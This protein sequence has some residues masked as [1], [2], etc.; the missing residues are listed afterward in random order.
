METGL[1]EAANPMVL[2]LNDPDLRL[3]SLAV[4][5]AAQL[6]RRGGADDDD[7]EPIPF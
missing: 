5:Y 3:V 6:S 7:D 1:P 2:L 4:Q